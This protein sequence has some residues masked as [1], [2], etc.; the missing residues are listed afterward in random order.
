MKNKKEKNQKSKTAIR[1][2][3]DINYHI[4]PTI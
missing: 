1:I 3:S 4:I 2:K